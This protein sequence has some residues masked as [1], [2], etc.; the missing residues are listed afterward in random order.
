VLVQYSITKA[1]HETCQRE[2]VSQQGTELHGKS[3]NLQHK[4]RNGVCSGSPASGSCLLN[5]S[6]NE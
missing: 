3:L 2:R 1:C 6:F 5:M 4:S